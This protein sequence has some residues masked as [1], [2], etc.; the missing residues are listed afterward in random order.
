[1]KG[2]LGL[3][4][5]ASV[6]IACQQMTECFPQRMEIQFTPQGVNGLNPGPQQVRAK[7]AADAR[8]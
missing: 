4:R 2:F 6:A 7:G 8:A 3:R 5:A 1:L